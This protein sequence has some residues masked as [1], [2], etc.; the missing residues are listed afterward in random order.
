MIRSS[1]EKVVDDA[2]N[3]TDAEHNMGIKGAFRAYP[4]AVIF[5]S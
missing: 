4:K 3:A 1:Q 2:A 5:S